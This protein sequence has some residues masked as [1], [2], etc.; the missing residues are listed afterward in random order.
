MCWIYQN[1]AK[2]VPHHYPNLKDPSKLSNLGIHLGEVADDGR[3][4][5]DNDYRIVLM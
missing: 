1:V 2:K 5:T 3:V 4:Y